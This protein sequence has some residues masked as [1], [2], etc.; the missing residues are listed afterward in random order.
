MKRPWGKNGCK[1]QFVVRSFVISGIILSDLGRLR[2][3]L[4]LP[5]DFVING[6]EKEMPLL[7][8]KAT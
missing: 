1:L 6:W 4:A 3:G 7:N 8:Q 5:G 2:G